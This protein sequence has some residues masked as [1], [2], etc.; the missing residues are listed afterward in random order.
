[1]TPQANHLRGAAHGRAWSGYAG[2][3]WRPTWHV[4][5]GAAI[6]VQSFNGEL[7][8]QNR[9]D[10]TNTRAGQNPKD[11][12]H[13]PTRRT[14]LPKV[15]VKRTIHSVPVDRPVSMDVGNNMS[16]RM[17]AVGGMWRIVVVRVIDFT[18]CVFRSRDNRRLKNERHRRCHH[19]DDSKTSTSRPRTRAQRHTSQFLHHEGRPSYTE[20]K[21]RVD[22]HS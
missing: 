14:G 2:G 19:H 1:M 15:I 7:A 16:F 10:R 18:R 13:A 4:R 5:F 21:R 17:A 9:F 8:D 20:L 3:S 22:T 6:A 12:G 11:N